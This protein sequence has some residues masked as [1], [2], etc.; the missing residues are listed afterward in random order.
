MVFECPEEIKRA[1]RARAGMD[2]L[3]PADVIIEA[4]RAFLGEE[5]EMAVRRMRAEQGGTA[6]EGTATRKAK[7]GRGKA[8]E[9]PGAS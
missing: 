8:G 7:R 5:I 1:I 3:S 6:A 2:G 9:G 4:L